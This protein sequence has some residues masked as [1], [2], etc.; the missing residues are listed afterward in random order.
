MA[1]YKVPQDVEADDKLIG[2]FSFRQFVYLLIVAGLIAIAVLLAQ[3][4]I[5]LAIIPIP[6]ILLF[7]AL[8]LPLRKDQ[9][10]ETYL[11]ALISFYLKPR[12]RIWN[13]GQR[14]ST[15]LITAP[16]VVEENRTR[17]I[18][19]EE[20]THRLSFLADIVDTQ[21]RAIQGNPMREDLMA[22]ANATED[23]FDS[24]RSSRLDEA[25]EKD[26][27]EHHSKVIDAMRKAISSDNRYLKQETAPVE[28]Q[29]TR[30]FAAA[31]A[32]ELP[33]AAPIAQP[34]PTAPAPTYAPIT[35]DSLAIKNEESL[36]EPNFRSIAPTLPPQPEIILPVESA[37]FNSPN[38]VQ[39]GLPPEPEPAQEPE[40]EPEPIPE[41]EPEP[42]KNTST[43]PPKPG[44]IELANTSDLSVA[45]IA[46]QANRIKGKDDG[47]VFISLH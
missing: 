36:P 41:M 12:K 2:P 38:V 9:P 43:I 24:Y 26:T 3:V 23:M 4:F 7:G 39:P 37:I 18:S 28:P 5:V 46:E 17:D 40:P 16:K 47:E 35:P 44:I 22:E 13:P 30:N 25:I 31:A 45:T 19:S 20:A 1:Q 11:A 32:P 15:I 33:V 10:M 14:E 6:L 27:E 42:Q 29:I 34:T 21:G 8:A